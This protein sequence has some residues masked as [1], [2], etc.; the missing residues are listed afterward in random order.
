LQPHGKTA[1][2]EQLVVSGLGDDAASRGDYGALVLLQYVL[3][4]TALVAP[5]TGLPVEQ[6][7]LR[8]ARTRFALDLAVELDKGHGQRL[9]ESRPEGGL[10]RAAQ[11]DERDP[12]HAL[13]ARVAVVA[14]QLR[15]HRGEFLAR[16]LPQKLG[17]KTQLGVFAR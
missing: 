5:V 14:H 2:K 9:G 6:E 13:V 7:D 1:R 17:G 16:E 4:A 15:V 11:S 8:Q 3:E 10:A 12:L